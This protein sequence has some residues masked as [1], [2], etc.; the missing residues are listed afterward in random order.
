MTVAL[1]VALGLVVGAA[2]TLIGAGG[3]FLLAPLLV[4]VDPR[5]PPS[6][7]TAISLTVVCLNA[8]SGTVAYA[9]MGRVDW[10]SALPFALASLPGA[11]LG[12]LAT[13]HMDRRVYDPLLGFGLLGI[14]LL[15]VARLVLGRRTDTAGSDP[16]GGTHRVVIERDGTRHAYAFSLPLGLG[17]SAFVGFL[18]SVLGIGG[19]IL[20]VPAMAQLLGFPV[21]VA[22]ATSH[23]VL[24]FMTLAGVLTHL[25][26]GSLV[27][28]LPRALPLGAGALV[29]AQAGARLSNRVRGTAILWGLALA[30]AAVGFRLVFVAA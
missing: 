16:K 4:F 27:R 29:G 10:R 7:L 17:I 8:S 28:A 1:L 26:D 30:L 24:A 23:A 3:G 2:G 20:H 13:R 12:A 14:A 22:T 15:V 6:V 18:S 5:D 19:G 21:H 11:V 9:R 25:A